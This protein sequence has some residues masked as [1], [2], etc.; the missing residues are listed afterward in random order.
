[1]T[2]RCFVGF[3]FGAIQAGLFLSEAFRSERFDRL[4]VAEVVPEVVES[5]RRDG[6]RYAVNVA[7]SGGLRLDRIEGV[8][9]LNPL[10]AEDRAALV[11]AAAE[12][13]E[14]ATAL[15]SVDF[16]D[17]GDASVA[18]ILAEAAARKMANADL[19][20]AIVYAGENN[21]QAAELLVEAVERRAGAPV[22]ERLAALN[23]VIGKMSGVVIGEEAMGTQGLEPM[24][25]GAGRA[26]LVEAFNR[27]LVS[28]VPWEGFE[29]GIGAFEEK[30]D[31]LP[32]EEAKLYGHNATHALIGYLAL[33]AGHAFM[34]DAG[35]DEELMALARAAFLKESGRGLI[36]RHGG[37]DP[38]FTEEGY[39]DYADDLLVRMVN[40][41]LR[42]AVDRIVRDP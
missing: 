11:D 16:F 41:H 25:S 29:R 33:E 38:L 28:R 14:M 12:A 32:F 8:E 7:E 40:P 31:L 26:F 35:G 19:P 3:G 1:M 4:V 15:P 6:G 34:S 27:I 10:V 20:R 22:G 39:R 9:I 30:D 2:T 37:I 5:V 36:A 17:K 24:T 42:D 21:N 13:S 18:A 23:T